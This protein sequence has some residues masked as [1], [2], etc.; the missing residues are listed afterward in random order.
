MAKLIAD[1]FGKGNKGEPNCFPR[2]LSNATGIEY[3]E[4]LMRCIRFGYNN[5]MLLSNIAKMVNSTSKM[6]VAACEWCKSGY[7]MNLE[8]GTAKLPRLTV[9]R[10][11]KYCRDRKKGRFIVLTNA[12]AFAIVNGIVYDNGTTG[13]KKRVVAIISCENEGEDHEW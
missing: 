5:G 4:A 8:F 10:F 2:A 1:C 13:L 7:P 3:D 6:D 9:D 11:V 12:H